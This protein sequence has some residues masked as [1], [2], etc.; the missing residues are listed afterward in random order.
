VVGYTRDD[1]LRWFADVRPAARI[2]NGVGLDNDEQGAPVWV[3]RE[4]VAPW[5]ELWPQLR[6]L[7]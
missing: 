5:A 7:G 6:R 3:A 1:L 2:D 4:P